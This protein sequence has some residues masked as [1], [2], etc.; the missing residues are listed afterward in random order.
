MSFTI[1]GTARA[2][3]PAAPPSVTESPAP[4]PA[5]ADCTK[6]EPGRLGNLTAEQINT[7]VIPPGGT[8]CT[9]VHL[10]AGRYYLQVRGAGV[11]HSG[12]VFRAD[13]SR[14]CPAPRGSLWECTVRA[15]DD[16]QVR[17]NNTSATDT[18]TYRVAAIRQDPADCTTRISTDWNA[19]RV[20]LPQTDELEAH[21]VRFAATNGE[22]ILGF[23]QSGN[24][25]VYDLDNVGACGWPLRYNPPCQ[26][27]ATGDYVAMAV[28]NPTKPDNEIQIRSLTSRAGCP[29]L[30]PGMLGDP[31]A[32]PLNGIRCRTIHVPTAGKYRITNTTATGASRTLIALEGTESLGSS[33]CNHTY[34]IPADGVC[35]FT[36]AGTFT[37]VASGDT[38]SLP[39]DVP[40]SVTFTHDEPFVCK[41]IGIF[42][43]P[44]PAQKGT[45]TK[46]G[47]VHC[48]EFTRADP[49]A[50]DV[51]FPPSA[52]GVARPEYEK[53]PS[54]RSGYTRVLFTAPAAGDYKF[55]LQYKRTMAY[56]QPWNEEVVAEFSADQFTRCFRMPQ[57]ITPAQLTTTIEKLSG[58]G[59]L[60]VHVNRDGWN[61]CPGNDTEFTCATGNSEAPALVLVGDAEPATYRITRT[62]TTPVS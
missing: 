46:A 16:Y 4:A 25:H 41:E 38:S 5:A 3:E 6:L 15:E 54:P 28:A 35:E 30:S 17:I 9:D 55:V 42:G 50:T 2:D 24:V 12:W 36:K 44:E 59:A 13:E 37:L 19:P 49:A 26:I 47:E 51:L 8:G 48:Y 18:M 34:W 31:T 27:R 32:D 22:N 60:E 40:Y 57:Y 11:A 10:P 53:V 58:S 21:C 1:T 29:E 23:S 33:A 45:F 56:C 7:V 39:E 20:A 43:L 14:L 61:F 62:P 52:T